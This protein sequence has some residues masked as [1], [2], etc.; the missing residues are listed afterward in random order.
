MNTNRSIKVAL[1]ALGYSLGTTYSGFLH[2]LGLVMRTGFDELM[3]ERTVLRF[4]LREFSLGYVSY[5]RL[6]SGSAI[7]LSV[8]TR[9]EII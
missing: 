3:Q 2:G 6:S 9:L 4:L 8:R 1:G 5:V 7:P